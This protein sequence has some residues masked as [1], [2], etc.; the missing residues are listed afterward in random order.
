LTQV[1]IDDSGSALAF[2]INNSGT[3]TADGGQVVLTIQSNDITSGIVNTGTIRARTLENRAG[4]VTLSAGA[5]RVEIDGGQIDVSGADPGQ[6]GGNINVTGSDVGVLNGARLDVS[7]QAGGGRMDLG[8][9]DG[10]LVVDASSVLSANATDNGNGG[11]IGLQGGNGGARI[12]GDL[13]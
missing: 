5:K 6:S 11:Y 10:T 12:F 7:G 4:R 13:S 1:T 2:D 9:N 8:S 3:L